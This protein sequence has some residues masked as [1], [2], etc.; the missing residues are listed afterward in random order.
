[1]DGLRQSDKNRGD[2]KLSISK[3]FDN[4]SVESKDTEFMCS[5]DT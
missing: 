2:T 4:V 1:M 3:V 5:H